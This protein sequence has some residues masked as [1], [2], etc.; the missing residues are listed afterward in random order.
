[1]QKIEHDTIAAISTPPGEG[2]IGI[3]RVSGKDAIAIARKVFRP[4]RGASPSFSESHRVHYGRVFS[5]ATEEVADEVLLTVMISPR[6]YT[7]ED[8]VEISCHGGA[9]PLS[10]VLDICLAEGAR[11]AEPGEFTK[12]AFL[13]GRLDLTQAEAVLDIIRSKTD[14]ARRVAL[15]QLEGDFSGE[16]TSLREAFL[17]TLA[18]IELTIDFSQEDVDFPSGGE[19][20]GRVERIRDKLK[21]LIGTS[22]KGMILREGAS[23]VICGKP[24]VGKSSLMNALLRHERVIVTSVAGT[25]RD[26][27]EEAVDISGIKVR[28]SDTAGIIETQ[29]RVEIEGIKRSREKL[30][31]SDVVLFVM[32]ASRP[33]SEKDIGIY[34]TIKHKRHVPVLNKCDLPLAVKSAEVEGVCAGQKPV[35]VSALKKEGLEKL[36]KRLEEKLFKGDAQI[37]E[38]VLVTNARHRNALKEALKSVERSLGLLADT[39]NAE[40]LASDLN[41]A[42]SQLGRITGET[43]PGDILDR[44]F[45]QFCIGK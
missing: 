13:N 22:E 3:V 6:T 24:N 5:P 37:P 8:M 19:I 10:R 31:E 42:L 36:E 27:I 16:V 11:L 44:I 41:E 25:T 2:G 28:I 35:E 40:L 1:M 43:V 7:K 9:M 38:G 20:S 32:D 45:S 34:Q 17:E 26:V 18:Q 12:R 4:A 21:S 23:V 30:E 14:T 39:F 33:L 29:D 15:R